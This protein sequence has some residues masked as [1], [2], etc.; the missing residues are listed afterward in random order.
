M[1]F[2]NE[3]ITG[4]LKS[5]MAEIRHLE[6]RHDVIFFC[7]GWSDLDKISQTGAEW[8]VDCGD[9][10]KIETR[11]R[12]PI[13][14]TF[15]RIPW[16]VILEPPATL[17]G[18]AT[19]RIQCHDPRAMCHIA[20]CCY[21]ANS[22]ACHP[23]ATYHIAR[24]CH[25]VRSLSWFQSHMPHCKVQ[26]PGEIN[27]MI[28]PAILTIVFRHISFFWFLKMQFGLWLAAAFVSSPIHLFQQALRK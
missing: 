16:H 25:L 2:F 22:T 12:I 15:G 18:A 19:W 3:P 13:R 23:R 1:G 9:M 21:R 10:V 20:G 28:V 27:V 8:H 14:R 26:S 11:C 7:W 5:K 24:C 4:R 6:N 17:Q